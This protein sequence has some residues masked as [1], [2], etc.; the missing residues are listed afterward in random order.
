MRVVLI[1]L[2]LM[3][4]TCTAIIYKLAGGMAA[5]IYAIYA[6]VVFISFVFVWIGSRL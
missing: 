4:I 1:L 3:G 6:L 2:M 5:I